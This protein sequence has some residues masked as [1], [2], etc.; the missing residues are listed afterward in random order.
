LF[1]L[2]IALLSRV[3][4]LSPGTRA[5]VK[6]GGGEGFEIIDALEK[7]ANTQQ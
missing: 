3:R 4:I 6:T 5:I 2:W 7:V 1:I